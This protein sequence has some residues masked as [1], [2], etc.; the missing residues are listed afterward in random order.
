MVRVRSL[1]ESGHG[2]AIPSTRVRRCAD[3]GASPS[4]IVFDVLGQP[5][6]ADVALVFGHPGDAGVGGHRLRGLL[7]DRRQGPGQRP[8]VHSSLMIA[9]SRS[10]SSRVVLR[11]E[12]HRP[13]GRSRSRCRSWR[14]CILSAGAFA[15]GDVVFALGN[16][17]DR[18]A[19]RPAGAK[20]LPLEVGDVPE[21]VPVKAKLGIQNLVL[22]RQGD[23]IRRPPRPVRPMPAARSAAGGSSTAAS[24]VPGTSPGSSWRPVDGGAARPSTTSRPTRSARPR[25][26]A[27]EARRQP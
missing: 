10:T 23:T 27:T 26:A 6:A 20:W 17:V 1:L 12:G 8:T 16:M 4:S 22:V 18:H 24:S 7:G 19:W 21:G 3:R 9:P 14:S 2:S 15:G 25:R 11:R 5:S 13:T